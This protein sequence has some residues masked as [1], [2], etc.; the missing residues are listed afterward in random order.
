MPEITIKAA[1]GGAFAA[2]HAKPPSGRGAG[3]VLIQEIF[4]VNQVMRDLADGYA[5]L[6]YT[7]C[8]PTC[9]GGSSPASRS[10][11][12]PRPN[13]RAPSSSTRASTSA[14]ASRT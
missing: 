5:Q 4:G 14:R 10:P 3:L 2:Y 8:A 7:C 11:T 1:D 13:G 6:G 9:S 12:R